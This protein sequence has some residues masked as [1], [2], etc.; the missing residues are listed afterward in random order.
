MRAHSVV[1]GGD[2]GDEESVRDVN[3]CLKGKAWS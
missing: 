3:R 2:R 1:D